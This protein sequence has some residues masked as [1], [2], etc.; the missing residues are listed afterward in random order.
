MVL[1]EL[2][3]KYGYR[4]YM[5]SLDQRYISFVQE[6]NYY[7]NVIGFF[8]ERRQT[9]TQAQ[10][11][12]FLDA[13]KGRLTYERPKDIHFLKLICTNAKGVGQ[14]VPGMDAH[15]LAEE[16]AAEREAQLTRAWTQDVWYLIDDENPDAVTGEAMGARLFVPQSAPEDFYGIKSP[17]EQ[18]VAKEGIQ[19]AL[20]EINLSEAER[21]QLGM[22]KA[23]AKEGPDGRPVLREKPREKEAACFVTLGLLLINATMYILSTFDIFSKD[24]FALTN[25]IL[26]IPGEWF[27]LFTYM[28]LHYDV[29]HLINNMLM[30]YAIGSILERQIDRWMFAVVYLAAGIGGGCISVWYH[31]RLLTPYYSM[32]A[33]GAI[34]GI[35]GALMAYL[36]LRRQRSQRGLYGRIGFALFLMF[37]TGTVDKQIDQMAHLGGFFCGL[38]VCGIYCLLQGNK[39]VKAGSK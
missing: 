19:I 12:G 20:P 27:R 14:L 1:N 30:L 33:S 36:L 24:D 4:I 37:Y 10:M 34:Y 5:C 8:D 15:G 7:I 22:D 31:T 2:F 6:E 13:H 21:T 16:E 11:Q 38:I 18:F 28:F 26:G 9:S 35:M 32:G 39:K 29:M 17:L 3:G 23:P 25:G